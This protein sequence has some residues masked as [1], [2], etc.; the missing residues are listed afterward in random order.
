MT[1]QH[2]QGQDGQDADRKSRL[3]SLPQQVVTID[4]RQ[5]SRH[6]GGQGRDAG[7]GEHDDPGEHRQTT[8]AEV[9]G[10][11]HAQGCGHAL[12]ALEAEEYREQV[13]QERRQG[14]EIG[15]VQ[16]QAVGGGRPLGQ[17][18]R[19]KALDGV[20]DQGE[21]GGG[22]PAGAQHVGGAGIPGTVIQVIPNRGVVIQASGGLVQGMWGNGRV[23]A[24]Q[25]VNLME[26]PDTVLTPGR[27]DVSL[28]G[29]IILG[30]ML[31]NVE[32]LQAIADLPA[33]GLILSSIQPALMSKAREM[34]F[35]VLVTDGIGSLPMNS[36]AYKLLSTNSK[37]EVTVNAEVYDRYTGARPEIII[38]LP[39]S[40]D[41]PMPNEVETFAV[42]QQ[43]K[44]RRPP[45]MGMIGSIVTI[46]PGLTVLPS[47]LRA[48]AAEVKLENN[49][50]VIV[51]LI[52]MEVVG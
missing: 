3:R 39:T 36:A 32:A 52:N 40:S 34:K 28:R 20:A 17:D 46:K 48:Q 13:A 26:A 15:R 31:K 45:S 38:P 25:L 49:E 5:G 37:R 1:R 10:Q 35:P 9:Q 51:P 24:G 41:P 21:G 11:Q 14:G 27:A 22:F 23:D 12:A 29:S 4:R 6:Q 7:D 43:V 19:R 16:R 18:H 8:K 33:R 44:M 47:G 2:Q 30:G 42:G 50:T